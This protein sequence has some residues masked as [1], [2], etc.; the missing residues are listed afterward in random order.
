MKVGQKVFIEPRNNAVRYSKEIKESKISKI[1]RKYFELEDKYFGRFYKD[2]LEQDAG[3]Y[4]SNY[5]VYFSLQEI[6]DRKEAQALYD[7]LKKY[8]SGWNSSLSL[9]Q[10]KS[11]DKIINCT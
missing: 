5:K 9:S 8:F 6:E 10:L 11:I 4:T 2:N 1:G 3:N 7:N